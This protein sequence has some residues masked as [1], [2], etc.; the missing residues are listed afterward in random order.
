MR[1]I[2]YSS[3][4]RHEPFHLLYRSCRAQLSIF[5]DTKLGC[6]HESALNIDALWSSTRLNWFLA[7]P[8]DVSLQAGECGTVGLHI[9]PIR[10][11]NQQSL[12]GR[13]QGSKIRLFET[14]NWTL[15]ERTEE[16]DAR[17]EHKLQDPSHTLGAEVVCNGIVQD[18]R[19]PRITRPPSHVS[20]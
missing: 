9:G 11:S 7:Y 16:G 8:G 20:R 13:G 10:A 19:G 12:C 17:A 1:E 2:L 15:A 18:T 5:E 14:S 3:V 6:L 4:T